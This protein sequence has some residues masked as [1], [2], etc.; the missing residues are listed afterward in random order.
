[1]WNFR[2][3]FV[4]VETNRTESFRRRLFIQGA[5]AK[6]CS[7]GANG[8]ELNPKRHLNSRRKLLEGVSYASDFSIHCRANAD[9]NDC[10][11]RPRLQSVEALL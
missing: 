8:L 1:V 10:Y 11:P 2:L 5:L 9:R 3:D 4:V 6:K 7:L